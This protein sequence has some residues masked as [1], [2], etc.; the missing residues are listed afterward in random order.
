MVG[1]NGAT[2]PAGTPYNELFLNGRIPSA[3][4][5][6]LVVNLMNPFVPLPTFGL[7]QYSFTSIATEDLEQGDHT[8]G[9]KDSVWASLFIEH[10]SV[11]RGLPFLG[12]RENF[13]AAVGLHFAYYNFARRH[14]ALRC[15][16]AMAA[17]VEQSFWTIGELLEEAA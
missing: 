8:F 16:P 10:E 13:E 14:N 5:N 3:D 2:Y 17:G 12:S 9:T 11:L 4:L 15:T 1:E 6:P 7:N